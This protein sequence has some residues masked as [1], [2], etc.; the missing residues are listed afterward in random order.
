MLMLSEPQR[1]LVR[2]KGTKLGRILIGFL[3]FSG[4]L[5]MLFIMGPAATAAYFTT[6]GVP[7]AGILVWA[8]IGLKIVAG[9][10]IMLGKRVGLAS[11]SLVAFTALATMLAH[12]S[13][14][15]VNLT[16]NLAIIG[17]LLY[18]MAYGP[19]GSNTRLQ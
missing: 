8:V 13:F 12:Q 4:G 15:D 2:D 7:M 14:E 1:D 10:A 11:A 16:K 6:L 18:L 3:F 9:G 5:S 17:G 19:G